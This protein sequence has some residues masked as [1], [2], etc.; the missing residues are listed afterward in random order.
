[1][2]QT[3]S[4]AFPW[5]S[6]VGFVRDGAAAIRTLAEAVEAALLPPAIACNAG[7]EPDWGAD[8]AGSVGWNIT[9]PDRV[10]GVWTGTPAG[11]YRLVIPPTPGWY[12]VAASY[13]FGGKS[14]ADRYQIGLQTRVSGGT[15]KFIW[16]TNQ[17]EIPSQAADTW[18]QLT[19]ASP[20]HVSGPNIG[21]EVTVQYDVGV[22]PAETLIAHK[23]R[24]HKLSNV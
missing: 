9:A 21:I 1:M 22:P 20:V 24:I 4:Y 19:I 15:D 5:P 17:V 16:L 8:H 13:R 7:S 14:T 10:R 11:N 12:M 6:P 2:G 18:S 3:T 23:L